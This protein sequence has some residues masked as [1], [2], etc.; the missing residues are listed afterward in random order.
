MVVYIRVVLGEI[1]R[2]R[3]VGERFRLKLIGFGFF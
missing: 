2:N 3:R 1:V